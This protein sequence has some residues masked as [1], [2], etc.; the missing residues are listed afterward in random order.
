[1]GKIKNGENKICKACGS[2]F[3]VSKYRLE[4]AKFC[5][6]DCQ[7]HKQY[8]KSKFT[9]FYC[10]ENFEDSPC[11]EGKRKFCSIECHNSHQ[12]SRRVCQKEARRLGIANARAKGIVGNSGPAIRKYAFSSKEKKCQICGFNEYECCL[13]VHHIDKDSNNNLLENLAILCVMCHRKVHRKIINI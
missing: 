12:T 5:C 9:C 3:Y 7:N 4:T 6:L 11:R 13:D 2:E 10:K 1:M 8:E